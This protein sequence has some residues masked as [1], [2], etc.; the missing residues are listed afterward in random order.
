MGGSVSK[1]NM[2]PTG[3]PAGDRD[4][5]QVFFRAV[6]CL[7]VWAIGKSWAANRPGSS[8]RKGSHDLSSPLH[9]LIRLSP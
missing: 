9:S 7:A 3:R 5:I 2:G 4:V 6:C 8:G 1:E